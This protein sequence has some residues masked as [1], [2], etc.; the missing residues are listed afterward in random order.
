MITPPY[1][2]TQRAK[3]T[4]QLALT[5]AIGSF[6]LPAL[7][8]QAAENGALTSVSPLPV[9]N[10]ISSQGLPVDRL[11]PMPIVV[12][13]KVAAKA[14]AFD[15]NLVTVLDGPF[16]HAQKIQRQSLLETK[17]DPLLY[18]FRR[19]A[20][21]PNPAKG[22]DYLGWATTGHKLA[23]YLSAC[24]MI[25]R[26]TGDLEIKKS[27]DE[28]V[29]KLAECQAA[30]KNGYLGGMP[31][32]CILHTEKLINEPA[33]QVGPAWYIQHK[34]YAGLLDMYVLTGNRQALDVLEKTI[35][36]VIENTN[37]LNE[38]KMQEMLG[39]EHGGMN[40]VLANLYSV[41]GKEKHLRLAQRFNHR[42]IIDALA[43]NQDV[44]DGLHANT[45]FPKFIGALRQYQLTGDEKLWKAA[46]ECW[47]TVVSERSYVTGGNSIGEAFSP[48]ARLSE[49]VHWNT[50]ETCNAHNMLKLTR[51]LFITEPQAQY[52]DYYERTLWNSILSTLHPKTGGQLYFQ[53]LESGRSKGS[54]DMFANGVSSCS[55]C[56]GTGQESVAKFADSIYLNDGAEGLFV[57]LFIASELNWKARGVQVRQETR[58]PDEAATRLVFSCPAPVGLTVHLRR[59][60]WA[61]QSF[62]IRINGK[63]QAITSV[64]GSYVPLQRQWKNGDTLD[65]LMPMTLHL[66]GFKDNPKRVAVMY[67][68][69]VM[70]GMTPRGNHFSALV[71][72][73]EAIFKEFKALEGKPLEF[74]AQAAICRTSLETVAAEPVVFKPLFR[75][76]DETYSV[77]WDGM[78]TQEFAALPAVFE[79]EVARHKAL[80]PKTVDL[81]LSFVNAKEF[82]ENGRETMQGYLL[83][84][85]LLPRTFEQVSEDAHGVKVTIG[86]RG[87]LNKS[88]VEYDDMYPNEFRFPGDLAYRTR[89]LP[90]GG[91][92]SYQMKVEPGASQ[93]CQIRLWHPDINEH[94]RSLKGV[95]TFEVLVDDQV[96]GTTKADD[97]PFNTF[98]DVSYPIPAELTAGKPIVTVSLRAKKHIRGIYEVRILKD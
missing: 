17:L 18:P 88:G 96:I 32:K 21:L 95:G 29:A 53:Q 40:E 47:E 61:T 11:D 69:L 57:N 7:S 16:K 27:A 2:N 92:Y 36:W 34:L 83:G 8:I 35:D 6:C 10:A 28:A 25:Y 56:A 63:K 87:W 72:E 81:V 30:M 1:K 54:W 5:C 75:V 26:N 46:R 98:V 60:W 33:F 94:G 80:E 89:Y 24:A 42:K 76:V 58:Y 13:D 23:H 97:L 12:P 68:P 4:L 71:G 65:V 37:Q 64:P 20:G 90:G 31:E 50:T 19:E 78:T 39:I 86:A 66:D 77:Y 9:Q 91:G 79:S 38:Q 55:C 49:H 67:G 62:E 51:G 15:L 48:K 43:E 22:S 85:G 73:K 70:A 82:R 41:T 14:Y 44:F 93:K 59:P 74:S 3:L 84:R 45:Q 52:A